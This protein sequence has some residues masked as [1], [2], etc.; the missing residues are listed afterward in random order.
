VRDRPVVGIAGDVYT[1]VN[2]AGNDDL[3]RWLEEQGLEVWPSPFQIDLLDFG[4]SR[5]L[6]RSVAALDRT[7]VLVHGAVALR[8]AVD[9]WRVRNVV[10]SRV[11]RLEEPGYL[12][13]RRLAAPYM[14]NEAQDLLFV[15]VAKI[16]DFARGGADGI[17]NAICFG[18][19]VG[20]ASAAVIERIR[21][22]F[23]DVPIVTAV[24][25]GADDP[26]RR[27][28]LEAFASQVKAHAE[29]RKAAAPP[30]LADRL[31]RLAGR[32]R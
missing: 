2:P 10:G 6:Y 18:C 15:N 12:E 32:A 17:V 8:R 7:G 4:I 27:M 13:M 19:M 11:T 5:G 14:P 26:S 21:R 28:V 23:D 3:V 16:V 31:Q 25:S 29:R 1:K 20:N 22:D 24:Y 9:V 30:S